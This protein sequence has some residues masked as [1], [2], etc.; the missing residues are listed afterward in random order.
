[1]DKV[2]IVR[3]I[4]GEDIIGEI[5]KKDGTTSVKHPY[6]IYPTSAP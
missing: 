5:S 4:T 6:I 3:L 1:M 2:K